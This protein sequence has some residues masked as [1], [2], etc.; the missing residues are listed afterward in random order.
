M[1]PAEVI[2]FLRRYNEWR[3]TDDRYGMPYPDPREIGE[4]ID[5]AVE[6]I[7]RLEEAEASAA[8]YE[9]RCSALQEQ[10]SNMRDPERTIVC[11]ILANGA[12]LPP[13]FAG[14]RYAI[15][16]TPEKSK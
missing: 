10:Q 16:D 1:T 4:A 12:V 7:E 11:D 8:W 13:D 15:K 2:T 14:D 6:M 5:A 9:R 3:R